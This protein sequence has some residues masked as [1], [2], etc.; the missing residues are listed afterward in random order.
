[1]TGQNV[2]DLMVAFKGTHKYGSLYSVL[3]LRVGQDSWHM[4]DSELFLGKAGQRT[5][6][7]KPCRK[8]GGKKSMSSRVPYL[9]IACSGARQ[10]QN[11][12][13]QTETGF[14]ELP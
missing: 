11:V 8:T 1:M 2:C 4:E 10:A 6:Y 13:Q 9:G 3:P 5:C 14:L 7:G 12:K